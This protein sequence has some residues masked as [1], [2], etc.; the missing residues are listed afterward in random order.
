[1]KRLCSSYRLL[2]L[3]VT[4]VSMLSGCSK[5]SSSVYVVSETKK[6]GIVQPGDSA[7]AVFRFFNTSDSVT[8]L[9][10]LPECDCTNVSTYRLVLQPHS[11]EKLYVSTLPDNRGEFTKYIYINLPNGDGFHT[12]SISGIVE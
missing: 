12:L 3:A 11:S 7:F 10:V 6:V 4:L 8:T 5:V 2:L 9:T 1:M